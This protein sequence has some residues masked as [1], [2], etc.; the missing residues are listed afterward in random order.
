MKIISCNHMAPFQS[1]LTSCSTLAF[2]CGML[3]AVLLSGCAGLRDTNADPDQMAFRGDVHRPKSIFVF[4]DGTRNDAGSGTN[5]RKLFDAVKNRN[6]R[7]TT[8][9]YI[10]GVGSA[11]TPVL[12]AGL[13]YG[14]E[15]RIVRSY[16]F[17]AQAYRPGDEIFII[18]FSRG[19]HQ[20]RALAGLLSYAGVPPQSAYPL[21]T[22]LRNDER[23][24]ELVKDENDVDY[25]GKWRDWRPGDAPLLAAAIGKKTKLTMVPVDVKFLGVWDTVPGS[26][27]KDYGVCKEKVDRKA[28]DRYKSDSYPPIRKIF[29]AVSLDEKRSRFS[30]LLL[31]PAMDGERTVVSEVWFSGAHADVGGGYGNAD[32]LSNISL[33]WMMTALAQ[34]Y[35]ALPVT[36]L[37]AD[38]MGLAHWSIGQAPANALSHCI[39]RSVPDGAIKDASVEKRIAAGNAPLHIDG[40]IQQRPYPLSCPK[41]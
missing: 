39:D 11:E 24:V 33:Q 16:D 35:S 27:F 30:P 29:H 34:S 37:E 21:E 12:G 36:D 38:A 3:M 40:T 25:V 10:E 14:M 41:T 17:I 26:A 19:A 22:R 5:V 2:L 18:G 32:G 7:Q 8:S 13:G 9:V 4:L 20:A 28:G 1:W 15:K 31:C 6:D 23:I